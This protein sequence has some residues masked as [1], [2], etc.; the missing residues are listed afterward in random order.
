MTVATACPR[1]SRRAPLAIC[2]AVLALAAAGLATACSDV[3]PSLGD[4]ASADSVQDGGSGKFDFLVAKEVLATDGEGAELGISDV[5]V[6]PDLGSTTDYG[7]PCLENTDCQSGYCVQGP[8]GKVCSKTCV[9]SCGGGWMCTQVQAGTDVAFICM[10]AFL[11]LCDPCSSNADCNETGGLDN[12]CVSFGGAGSFCGAGCNPK[13]PACPKGYACLAATNPESGKVAHQCQPEDGECKCSAQAVSKKLSTPCSHKNVLG[14]CTGLRV[15]TGSGL[16][17]CDAPVPKQE[18]CNDADDDCDGVTDDGISGAKCFN[19][20]VFGTCTGQATGCNGGKPTCSAEVPKAEV[21]NSSDDDCDGATDELLCDDGNSCTIDTCNSDG[22]CKNEQ[23]AG[24]GCDDGN[25]CTGKDLCA[26]GQCLGGDIVTC[27]DSNPCTTDACDPLKGCV[28]TKLDAVACTED[29]N[30]CTSDLCQGGTCVNAPI[31]NG[32]ACPDDGDPCTGDTCDGGG[33]CTHTLGAGTCSIGGKCMPAG[34]A[35]PNDACLVCDPIQNKNAYVAKNGIACDD[36]NACSS[37][38]TCTGGS[39]KGKAMDCSAKDGACTTGQC[40]DGLCV[41]TPKTAP[42]D[43]GNP[44]TQND[45]C[46]AGVCK[47]L[48][49]DCSALNDSCHVGACKAGG[50]VQAPKL[51]GC[52]DG[53]PCTVG[54]SCAGGGCKGQPM[55]CSALDSSCSQGQCAGGACVAKAVNSGGFCNDGNAC[56]T[57]DTCGNGKCAGAAKSCSYLDGPCVVGSCANGTCSAQPKSGG[58]S[59]GNACTVNDACNGGK[60]NGYPLDCNPFSTACGTSVCSNGQCTQPA[61]G[62]CSPGQVETK[63]QA[64][65]SCGSQSQSRVCTNSCAWGPWSSFGTCTGQGVCAPGTPKSASQ[66]CGNCGTQS[67][68]QVC[69]SSCQWG[70]FGPWSTCSGQGVCKAG[71]TDTDT[72]ACGNCGTQSRSRACSGS[73]AWGAYGAWSTCGG[74]GVCQWKSGTNFKCCGFHQWQFCSQDCEWFPCQPEKQAPWA[75]F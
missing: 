15:C 38:D 20:N 61:G 7:Q 28:H 24:L 31:A 1:N 71:T 17:S 8:E 40:K 44:C 25:A 72:Q 37:G 42:C 33:K 54:D 65:G 43:D 46:N 23:K 10:P 36:G 21:C 74:Q 64:C 52:D 45:N 4:D 19:T 6:A 18:E 59:D 5:D 22:S 75:C 9:E 68:T 50:C 57:N 13:S 49:K 60:C 47:G 58:C 35:S 62:G 32:K 56:T 55:D 3:D 11:R 14:S 63:S 34:T 26:T 30:P 53:N 27:Q 12:V 41:A 66:A 70:A 67:H 39:C 73:C 16:S 2:F 29:G 51:G 69:N 48:D